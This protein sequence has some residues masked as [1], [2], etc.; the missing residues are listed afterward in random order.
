MLRF[1]LVKLWVF[2][3]HSRWMTRDPYVSE[4]SAH[5]L[6]DQLPPDG[7]KNSSSREPDR[8]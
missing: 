3:V 2:R 5:D 4:I 8:D 6:I 7:E 1:F